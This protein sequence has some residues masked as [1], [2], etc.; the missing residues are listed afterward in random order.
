MSDLDDLDEIE[1]TLSA[2]EAAMAKLDAGTYGSCERCG[3]PLDEATLSSAPTAGL[4][5]D[6][7]QA[8]L[9]G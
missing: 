8:R 9:D 1:A 5:E 3:Q 2:V 4:C 7:T 6:C